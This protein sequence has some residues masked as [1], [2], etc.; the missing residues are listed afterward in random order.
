MEAFRTLM[1]VFVGVLGIVQTSW[2]HAFLDHAEPAVGSTVH[3]SPA[4]LKVWFTEKLEQALCKL[5]VFDESGREVAT[6]KP[7]GG[8]ETQP[9][10]QFPC[11]RLSRVNTK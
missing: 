3:A 5:Q 10:L 9:C 11:L 6:R 8:G 4:V 1:L 2:A 7:A